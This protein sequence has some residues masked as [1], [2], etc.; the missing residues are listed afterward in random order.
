MKTSVAQAAKSNK[1]QEQVVTSV[2]MFRFTE[3]WEMIN[4]VDRN[5]HRATGS[6]LPAMTAFVEATAGIILLTTPATFKQE[7]EQIGLAYF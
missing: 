5:F 3:S 7:T 6:Y 1:A 2:Y 4:T